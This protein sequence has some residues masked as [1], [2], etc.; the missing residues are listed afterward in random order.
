[1]TSSSTADL[2]FAYI[3]EANDFLTLF[4]HRYDFIFAEHPQPGDRP[5][6]QTESRYPV[7][8][9]SLE[10][11]SLLYG[12][13]FGT[14]TRYCLLDIDAGSPY[15]PQRD[16]LAI[17]RILA[18]LEPLGMGAS[19]CCTSSYSGGIHLYL[20]FRQAH[21]S[22]QVAI[23]LSTLLANAGFSLKP[24]QLEIF[25]N[26]KGYTSQ[27]SLFNAHRLPM[28]AGSYLLNRDFQPIWGDRHQFIQQ[29]RSAQEHND[30][31]IGLIK[32]I[33]RQA[34]HQTYR[35]SGK[36]DKFIQDLNTEIE[37][38]WTDFGQTN[39][40]LGRIAMR[41]YIF[42][43]V[44][45]GGEPLVGQRL[46]DQIAITARSLPGYQQW[47]RHQREIEKRASEWAS[48][49]ENSAYFPYGTE[50]GKFKAKTEIADMDTATWN[51][52][53]SALAREKI[54]NA[55]AD[56]LEKNCL[57]I[58]ITSR[59]QV[60]TGYGIG[61]S[62]LYR[63]RDLWHPQHLVYS[64]DRSLLHS[65]S[66]LSEQGRNAPSDQHLSDF[67]S[68]AQLSGCNQAVASP[69]GR[70]D[71]ESIDY[72]SFQQV[73]SKPASAIAQRPVSA[74][75]SASPPIDA[76]L[77]PDRATSDV[78]AGK[79]LGETRFCAATLTGTLPESPEIL[80]RFDRLE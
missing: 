18:A 53:Q 30:L 14:S 27:K 42:H 19:V 60:L 65:P 62:S 70:S 8:D 5:N 74:R 6:W 26:R 15:H 9:R 80:K 66:L 1:M 2:T 40:L 31:D 35:L 44:L 4:P 47:C 77:S 79:N 39:R 50:R 58:D 49:I 17:S 32:R 78:A 7:S 64:D 52:K 51:E 57:P 20:P 55:V 76:D 16:T 41:C 23:G 29:W 36:A 10:E 71:C 25:P 3:P 59:F 22:W 68:L 67:A 13:R 56:L 43:H 38:G 72:P 54:K 28:Q 33:L 61:G 69:S 63:H 11:G 45:W 48:C 34:K 12:V 73:S 24:G 21:L 46:T 75:F 37:L